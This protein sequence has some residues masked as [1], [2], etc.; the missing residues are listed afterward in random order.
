MFHVCVLMPSAGG[1]VYGTLKW[2]SGIHRVQRV[3]TT[4]TS[5]RVHTSAASV[6]VLAEADQV[7]RRE[8]APEEAVSLILHQ[9]H[10][11]LQHR[12]RVPPAPKAPAGTHAGGGQ[13]PETPCWCRQVD[14][15]MRDED[16]RIDTF[17]ASGAGG[18]HVNTTDSAVRITHIPTGD[19]MIAAG[20]CELEVTSAA[21]V[22]GQS[23]VQQCKCWL[24]L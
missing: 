10:S 3:P 1:D 12:I 9:V 8:T 2:E 20:G 13:G 19:E 4:E 14:V 24:L 22:Y 21:H 23:M 6:V 18:Q 5:G 17:R 7:G 15:D 11:I 16:V